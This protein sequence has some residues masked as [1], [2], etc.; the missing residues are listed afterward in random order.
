MAS[1]TTNRANNGP[2]FLYQGV[3]G[4]GANGSPYVVSGG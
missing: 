3:V 2:G 1:R 4:S